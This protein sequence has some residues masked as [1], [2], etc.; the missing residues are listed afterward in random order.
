MQEGERQFS[1]LAVNLRKWTAT[2]ANVCWL[3]FPRAIRS[4]EE[5]GGQGTISSG[6]DLNICHGF[7]PLY[8]QQTW[9]CRSPSVLWLITVLCTRFT[10]FHFSASPQ[11]MVSWRAGN[12]HNTYMVCFSLYIYVH[13][14][15]A[16]LG[17]FNVVWLEPV[18][19]HLLDAY[20]G[21]EKTS[22]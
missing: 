22:G 17:S 20:F 8:S 5:G 9:S 2:G 10:S 19:V 4:W 7:L 13:L 16:F 3:L 11:S 6:A 18:F 12:Q 21:M 15:F 14:A 1:L